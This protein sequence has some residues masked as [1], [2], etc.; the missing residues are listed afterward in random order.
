MWSI[1]REAGKKV[2][3]GESGKLF[4]F[5][6]LLS[7]VSPTIFKGMIEKESIAFNRYLI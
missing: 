2:S 1:P 3:K 6:F 5:V 4:C 7:V